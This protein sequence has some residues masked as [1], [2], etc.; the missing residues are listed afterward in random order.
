M[1]FISA[2]QLAPAYDVVLAGTG[3]GSLFFAHKLLDRLPVTSKLL[4]LERGAYR[5]HAQRLLD[6]PRAGTR[7]SDYVEIKNPAEK[8]WQFTIGLGGGTLCWWGQSTRF[9]PS[10]FTLKTRHG[11]ARD[12]PYTY[13]DLEP[14]YCEAEHIIGVSGDSD[15][16]QH[17]P[18]S[19][20]YPFPPHVLSTPDRLM[21]AAYPGFHMALPSARPSVH[22]DRR[23][24]C[25]ANGNCDYCP[26]DAKFTALN[27]MGRVLND[28]RVSI[29]VEAGVTHLDVANGL[30]HGVGF[31]HAGRERHV[32]AAHVVLGANALFNPVILAHS[33]L[34]HPVLGRRL[35]DQL[36]LLYEV[37]LSDVDALD[38]GSAATGIFLGGLDPP[39]RARKGS[40]VYNFD[41][42]WWVHGLRPDPVKARRTFPLVVMIEEESLL[43]NHVDL[44]RGALDRPQ[45]NHV[46]SSTYGAAGMRTAT[47]QLEPLLAPLGL[48]AVRCTDRIR[49]TG[50]ILGTT[51]MGDD[52]AEAI[53]DA[54]QIHHQVRN[55]HVVGTSVFPTCGNYTPAL[56][57][58]AMSLRA[59]DRFTRRGAP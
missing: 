38:G 53:V 32:G 25:C 49:S 7:P 11:I 59:A 15:D 18:R 4:F 40:F 17:F 35:S 23:S 22:N 42:R 57:V 21:K 55:L 46:E 9:H 56:T 34:A 47:E 27:G 33:G 37:Q 16:T 14:Y 52:P 2:D 12:W 48:D 51:M 29:L 5:D 28:P 20:P 10:A 24:R 43:E 39:D 41:N 45:V 54:D 8:N 50:H 44:S 30:A 3:F 36:G 1:K 19:R 6:G 13:G 58:A 26:S 31:V